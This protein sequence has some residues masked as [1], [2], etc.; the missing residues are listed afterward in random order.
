MFCA[1]LPLQRN[2]RQK[3]PAVLNQEPADHLRNRGC[4]GANGAYQ[5]PLANNRH[6]GHIDGA[7]A[8]AMSL[9]QA[10]QCWKQGANPVE[11]ARD[12]KEFARAF[13]SFPDDADSIYPGWRQALWINSAA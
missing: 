10:G 12:H 5:R 11:F 6:S 4:T 7:A 2:Q 1:L 8:G 3:L 13:E 9:R